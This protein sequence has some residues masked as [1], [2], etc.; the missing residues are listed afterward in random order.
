MSK[1]NKAFFAFF[2]AFAASAAFAADGTSPVDQLFAAVD[3]S[4][5]VTF[6]ASAGVTIIGISLAIKGISL[7]KRLVS[8]A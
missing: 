4:T 7:A 5:V 6:V 1:F 3:L 8:K 2:T